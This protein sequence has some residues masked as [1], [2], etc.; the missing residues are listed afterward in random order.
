MENVQQIEDPSDMKKEQI[1]RLLEHWRRRVSASDLFRFSHVLVNTKTD[2]IMCALYTDPFVSHDNDVPT[3]PLT[4][5]Q[6]PSESPPPNL[7]NDNDV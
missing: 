2:E 7:G 1:G 3:D 6:H 4:A 5:P